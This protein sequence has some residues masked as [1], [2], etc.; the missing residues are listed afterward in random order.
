MAIHRYNCRICKSIQDH[1]EL[2]EFDLLP[3]H[4]ICGQCLG[5]GVVGIQMVEDIKH[6][7]PKVTHN[8]K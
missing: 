3:P 4:V 6:D 7:T 5:C 2:T 8:V 1:K